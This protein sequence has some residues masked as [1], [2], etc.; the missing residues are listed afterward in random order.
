MIDEKEQQPAD[1]VTLV[2]MLG[3]IPIYTDRRMR[4]DVVRLLQPLQGKFVEC[5]NIKVT[6]KEIER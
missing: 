6:R 3:G 2:G 5:V 1:D 4:D